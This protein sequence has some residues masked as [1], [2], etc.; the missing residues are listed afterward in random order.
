MDFEF[1]FFDRLWLW[2]WVVG[3][4][5]ALWVF[6]AIWVHDGGGG[7]CDGFAVVSVNFCY[8]FFVGL[9]REREREIN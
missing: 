7:F 9:H 1:G 5:V 2:W 6:V 8:G 4:G 3:C